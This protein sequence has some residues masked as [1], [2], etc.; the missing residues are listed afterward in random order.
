ME[1][2]LVTFCAGRA[3]EAIKFSSVTGG[4]VNDIEQ[5]TGI[6]K[7][8]VTM[9]GM[10]DEIGMVSLASVQNSY[11]DGRAYMDCSAATE[12]L[13]DKEVRRIMKDSYDKAYKLLS[14]HEDLLDAL[15]AYLIEKETITGKEFMKIYEEITGE[16]LKE[17]APDE[18]RTAKED[19][20]VSDEA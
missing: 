6:A 13:V 18:K 9:F 12:K 10:S 15:A 4:A 20:Q 14:E 19:S 7:R 17:A 1:E 5:A 3:A 8:M 11:L 2:D 16:K